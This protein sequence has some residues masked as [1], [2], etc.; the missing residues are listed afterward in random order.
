MILPF[1]QVNNS[2]YL[3]YVIKGKQALHIA[4][5]IR[6]SVITWRVEFFSTLFLCPPINN[7]QKLS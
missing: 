1:A 4:F 3:T 5:S 2:L 7:N 6:F